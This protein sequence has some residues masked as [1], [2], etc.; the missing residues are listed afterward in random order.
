MARQPSQDIIVRGPF[1]AGGIKALTKAVN[2]IRRMRVLGGRFF[3]SDESCLLQLDGAVGSAV[4]I[5]K[6][7]TI[8]AGKKDYFMAK[9]WDGTTLGGT[10]IA[11][12]KRDQQKPSIT[13]VTILG[14]DIT[15]TYADDNH[16]TSSDGVNP[17][18]SEE[19]YEPYEVDSGNT[20]G[21]VY[22]GR[23][24]NATGVVDADGNPVT[25][26]DLTPRVW[27]KYA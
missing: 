14:T 10:E 15:Y 5:Y 2:A 21:I 18:Q 11:I 6:I 23:T 13:A 16:R 27:G 25:W 17:D 7:S 1:D 12:A 4:T 19:V 22:A 20:S 26:L 24:T 8:P 9:T 3:S